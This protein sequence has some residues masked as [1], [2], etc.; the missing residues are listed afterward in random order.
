MGNIKTI[1]EIR[2]EFP[3]QWVL[4]KI[5]EITKI[6]TSGEVLLS[7]KDYLELCYKSSE[8]TK[9]HYTTIVFTSETNKTQ[10]WLK[11]SHLQE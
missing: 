9:D 2:K 11:F 3:N 6:P 10:K 7:N 1:E 5:N 4:L 8:L